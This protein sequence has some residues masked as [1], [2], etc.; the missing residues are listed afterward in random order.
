MVD[1][2]PLAE[3]QHIL[4]FDSIAQENPA[5]ARGAEKPNETSLERVPSEDADI[6]GKRDSIHSRDASVP[7]P[8][9]LLSPLELIPEMSVDPDFSKAFDDAYRQS[10]AREA[11]R[12]YKYGAGIAA[13]YRRGFTP[14]EK[15][16]KWRLVAEQHKAEADDSS[17]SE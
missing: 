1:D 8:T 2:L 4:Y 9:N 16:E 3:M 17:Q 7:P 6:L 5:S 12:R 14:D 11:H 15:R 10:E 13:E